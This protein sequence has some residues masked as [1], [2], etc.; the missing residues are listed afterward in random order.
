MRKLAIKHRSPRISHKIWRRNLPHRRVLEKLHH[1]TRLLPK[2]P[3]KEQNMTFLCYSC[4]Y[5]QPRQKTN[6]HS[7]YYCKNPNF[8]YR[9]PVLRKSKCNRYEPTREVGEHHLAKTFRPS[10]P[11]VP[12]QARGEKRKRFIHGEIHPL[13]T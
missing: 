13:P 3:R 11:T 10:S 5:W 6:S 9:C 8:T 4:K 12:G 7:P 2:L 1:G